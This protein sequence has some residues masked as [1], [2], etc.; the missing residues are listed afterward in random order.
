MSVLDL[1]LF[2][3][4]QTIKAMVRLLPRPAIFFLGR[5][6]GFLAYLSLGRHRSI[7]LKNLDI[8]FGDNLNQREKRRLAKKS[9]LH[10]GQ[11]TLDTIKLA[12]TSENR[13]NEIIRV[14]GKEHL[15]QAFSKGRGVLIFSAHLGNWEVASWPVSQVAAL[16]V[17]ARPLDNP[18]L[19]K[20][21][22][23]LRASLGAKVISK[24]QAARPVLRV[25]QANGMV[26][27]LIDQNVL[28]SQALFV[29]FFGRPAA[30]TPALASFHLHSGAPL[31]PVFSRLEADKGYSVKVHPPLSFTLNNK[32]EADV[33]LQITQACTKMIEREIGQAPEQWLWFHDRWRTR[34]IKDTGLRPDDKMKPLGGRRKKEACPN[35]SSVEN[36]KGAM[37][38]N[39]GI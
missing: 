39:K 24:F 14:E 30:T 17:V 22:R 8:A 29:E 10:F 26:A 9:F 34:P 13:R 28:R 11:T 6:L 1:L 33:L 36:S 21:L 5:C 31:V 20:Q 37:L 3:L 23:L 7:A 12:L 32:L 18:W 38:K 2:F 15:T 4:F 35:D 25:L 19:E 16:H 27:L